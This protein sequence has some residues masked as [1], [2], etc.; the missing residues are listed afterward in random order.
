MSKLIRKI[1]PET[2]KEQRG[3]IQADE[4]EP[5]LGDKYY[6]HHQYGASPIWSFIHNLKKVPAITVMDST[7]RIIIGDYTLTEKDATLKFN[8]AF[9]GDAYCD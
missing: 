6:H 5:L 9:A 3:K 8:H 1:D 4:F 7:G 2:G